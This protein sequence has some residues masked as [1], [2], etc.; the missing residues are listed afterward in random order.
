M[1]RLR[2]PAAIA[3]ACVATLL[4]ATGGAGAPPANV[5]PGFFGIVPQTT[6]TAEDARYMA[7]G[8]IETVRVPIPWGTVQPTRHGGYV[9]SG[10]DQIVETTSLAGLR[11]LPFLYGTPRW[12]GKPTALPVKNAA[13]R[14]AWAAFLQAAV[15]R[16]GPGGEFWTIHE[17]EGVN[18]EP[19]IPRPV[20]I[21]T[22][23]IWNEANFFYFAFPVSPTAYAKLL[24]ASS[25]AIKAVDPRAKVVLSGLFGEPTASGKR[26]MPAA[27]FLQR[28]Y[29]IPGFKTRF[30]G[31]ALH[32]Y[33]VD[34][35]TLEE[36][37]EGIHEVSR[38]A[39]DRP[40]LYVTEMGW[41]SQNNF[42]QVAFEQGIRGQ[43]RQLRG[44]YGYL[45]ENQRR[46]HLKGAYW[47][48]WKDVPGAC[49]FC[50]SVGLFRAG[51]K[52]RPKPA[53]RALLSFTGGRARP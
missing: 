35:E 12:L 43:V 31:V 44:A 51:K 8:G 10:V 28:L 2:F 23:Q 18:Y 46:L 37:V 47:F 24:T 29:A 39:H 52:F 50:D 13:Q 48:S 32:P 42:R 19:A 38:E 33:A 1:R 45:T 34:T 15:A 25:R 6:L 5:P 53:W 20:P 40:D 36:Q 21:R 30:D 49:N 26:G 9:W 4:P 3:L 17:K 7:A 11:V 14:R 16:Y 41:G 27:Q 22:W